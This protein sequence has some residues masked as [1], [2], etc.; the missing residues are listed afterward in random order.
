[1]IDLSTTSN[2]IDMDAG[3]AFYLSMSGNVTISLTN[4]RANAQIDRRVTLQVDC[5]SAGSITWSGP[6]C[7]AA[8]VCAGGQQILFPEHRG[9]P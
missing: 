4:V 3:N 2:T 8:V 9:A 6:R 1:M 7:S 5:T